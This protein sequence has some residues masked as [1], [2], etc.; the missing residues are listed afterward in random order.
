MYAES[1][2]RMQM[3][4]LTTASFFVA[5]LPWRFLCRKHSSRD[6]TINENTRVHGTWEVAQCSPPSN[7]P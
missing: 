6:A 2:F 4:H 7:A 1:A 5:S 3:M